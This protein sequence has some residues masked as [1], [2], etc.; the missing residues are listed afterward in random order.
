MWPAAVSFAETGAVRPVSD[1]RLVHPASPAATAA[2]RP[3]NARRFEEE[4]DPA[5]AP[6]RTRRLFM[7]ASLCQEILLLLRYAKSVGE[8]VKANEN[9]SAAREDNPG[10][11][12]SQRTTVNIRLSRER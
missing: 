1:L 7:L 3:K 5:D 4:C 6:D 10:K 12:V 9:F 2:A 8:K 11:F